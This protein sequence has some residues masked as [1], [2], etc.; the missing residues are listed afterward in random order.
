M[1]LGL[2]R[3]EIRV[4]LVAEDVVDE[5]RIDERERERE[6]RRSLE[7]EEKKGD[8]EV[9]SHGFW[10]MVFG[11]E[12]KLFQGGGKRGERGNWIFGNKE[13]ECAYWV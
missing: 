11:L 1:I 13:R 4:F 10:L 12:A 7:G 8:F 2:R 3:D 5:R 6:L 9:T